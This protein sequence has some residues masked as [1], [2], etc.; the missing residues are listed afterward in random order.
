MWLRC[1]GGISTYVVKLAPDRHFLLNTLDNVHVRKAVFERGQVVYFAEYLLLRLD[2]HRQMNSSKV[3]AAKNGVIDDEL[4]CELLLDNVSILS[5][6][7]K[8]KDAEYIPRSP[9]AAMG[10]K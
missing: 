4:V 10:S 7:S 8:T 6:L 5:L 2:V 9:F 1:L 3:S